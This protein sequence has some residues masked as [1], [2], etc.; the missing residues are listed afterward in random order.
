MLVISD[1]AELRC[2]IEELHLTHNEAYQ[3]L[4]LSRIAYPPYLKVLI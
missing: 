1:T 4:W 2:H 3:P